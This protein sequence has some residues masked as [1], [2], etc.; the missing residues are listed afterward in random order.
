LKPVLQALI[1][2]DRVYRDAGSGK[3]IIAGTFNRVLIVRNPSPPKEQ[4]QGEATKLYGGLNSGSPYAFIS[5]T[6]VRGDTKLTLRYVDLQDNNALFQGE[7][8][9]NAKSPLDTVEI[10]LPLPMLPMP[11]P[12]VYALELLCNEE[13]IGSLRIMAVETA[14]PDSEKNNESQGGT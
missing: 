9:V 11:H 5:L 2:A 3:H 8:S 13:P 12:G 7:A 14:A 10:V 6:D 1:V 4:Q